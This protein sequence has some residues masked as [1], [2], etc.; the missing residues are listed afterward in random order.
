MNRL[1]LLLTLSL[2]VRVDAADIFWLKMK[3]NHTYKDLTTSCKSIKHGEELLLAAEHENGRLTRV[4]MSN[5]PYTSTYMAIYKSIELTSEQMGQIELFKDA[6][7]HYW[8]KKFPLPGYVLRWILVWATERSS[9]CPLPQP[10]WTISPAPAT[11]DFEMEGVQEGIF[12]SYS[13]KLAFKGQ[14]SD[15]ESYEATLQFVQREYK[16]GVLP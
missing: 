3:F 11:Y 2:T 1:F 8:V 6:R 15:G 7:G 9:F 13:Q 4:I 14:R 12:T 5:F 10:L 16:P